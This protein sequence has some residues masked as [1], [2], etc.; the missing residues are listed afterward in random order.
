MKVYEILSLN[1]ELFERLHDFGITSE[2]YRWVPLYHEFLKMRKEGEKTVYIVAF[3]SEK[4]NICERKIY[5]IIQTMNR[6][7]QIVAVG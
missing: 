1:R 3:L 2:D 5:K 4:Y 7:C 6:D